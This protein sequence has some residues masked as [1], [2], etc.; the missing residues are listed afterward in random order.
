MNLPFCTSKVALGKA[1]FILLFLLVQLPGSGQETEAS[2]KKDVSWRVFPAF[3]SQPETGFVFGLVGAITLSPTDT[4]AKEFDRPSSFTPAAILSVRNQFLVEFNIDYFLNS[5]ANLNITP[6]YSLFPDR[7]FGIGNDNDPDNFENY[8]NQFWQLEG[9]LSVPITNKLFWGIYTDIQQ[10]NLKEIEAGGE[11]A[12]GTI[13]GSDGGFQ[14]GFGPAF[15]LDT[16]DN[17]IYPS[18][19]YFINLR[20][21]VTFLGD[22][23][24]TNHRVDLR[25]Y[26]SIRDDRD[27][28]AVQVNAFFTSGSDIPFY[29][30][31]QLGGST[32]LRGITNASVYRDRQLMYAQAE[33]RKHLFWKVGMVAFAGVGDVADKAS[34][35]TFSDF[36]YI[37]GGGFRFQL[38]KEQKLNIRVDYGLASGGQSAF[39][40]SLRESF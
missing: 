12:T 10:S 7:Y 29:K 20:T 24:Y 26:F 31:P 30:L 8:T 35:F 25:R 1:A 19:G 15:R 14:A 27:V 17:A 23:S 11:L 40:I 21:L 13:L 22:F 6:L 2:N 3:G 16:R 32:R 9:Q 5:G 38:F 4:T 37:G 33:Y 39:Y 28:V 18:K 34:E 36:K